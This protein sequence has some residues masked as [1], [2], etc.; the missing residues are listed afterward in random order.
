MVRR[1]DRTTHRRLDVPAGI[2]ISRLEDGG[3]VCVVRDVIDSR[4]RT[5]GLEVLNRASR[6]LSQARTAEAVAGTAVETVE[7]LLE[8]D[9]ACVRL[10]DEE[11]NSFEPVAIVP[12][13]QTAVPRW[14]GIT[15]A[16]SRD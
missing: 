13:D 1:G 7:G 3:Y 12:L 5:R 4:R 8:T 15:H 2:P 10:F 9:I 6:D 16:S 14:F 11:S